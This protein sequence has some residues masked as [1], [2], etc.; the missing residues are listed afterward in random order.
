MKTLIEILYNIITAAAPWAT[1]VD[2]WNEQ[3][4]NW[5]EEQPVALP[6]IFIEIETGE[7]DNEIGEMNLTSEFT[8]HVVV[9]NYEETSSISPKG[10]L[11]GF[12]LADEL[13]FGLSA[14]SICGQI[15][16]WK[17]CGSTLAP[18]SWKREYLGNIT[19]F[20]L[21]YRLDAAFCKI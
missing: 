5:E 6:A 10:G 9:E 17:L 20:Q 4:A 1:A 15:G 3:T 18:K 12:E 8:L 13:L 7:F 19:D 16:S 14:E 2:V 11:A 21:T